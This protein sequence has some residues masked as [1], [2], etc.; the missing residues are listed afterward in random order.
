MKVIYIAGP[1]RAESN[2]QI[3]LNVRK[4][5]ELSLE[6]WKRGA[7]PICPHTMTRFFQNELPDETWLKGFIELL[8]RCDAIFLLPGWERS[9]GTITE[10]VFAIDH[11][12][13][14]LMDID[15][16]NLY[17]GLPK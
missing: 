11:N 7:V 16:L 5:E 2:W 1:Y 12:M 17:A 15:D 13:K 4:A 10:M 14:V 8:R 9:Q 3:E 6:V